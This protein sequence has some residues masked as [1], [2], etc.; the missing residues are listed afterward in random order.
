ML[1]SITPEHAQVECCVL[2]GCFS[3]GLSGTTGTGTGSE[4]C[5]NAQILTL[6]GQGLLQTNRQLFIIHDGTGSAG[7]E[8]GSFLTQNRRG[9]RPE[10]RYGSPKHTQHQEEGDVAEN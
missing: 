2:I 4:L 5:V 8:S 9:P 3:D 6:Q 1:L 10:L 7:P